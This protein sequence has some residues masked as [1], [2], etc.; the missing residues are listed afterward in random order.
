MQSRVAV[1][2][3]GQQFSIGWMFGL[4]GEQF[5][6]GRERQLR[7]VIER[8]PGEL[9]RIE[10]MRRQDRSQELAQAWVHGALECGGSTPLPFFRQLVIPGKPKKE[11]GVEPPHSKVVSA[12]EKAIAEEVVANRRIRC[13]IPR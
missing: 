11:S 7:P 12:R 1:Q 4:A 10:A 13:D 6:L 2:R 5:L 8:Q 9:A 3:V